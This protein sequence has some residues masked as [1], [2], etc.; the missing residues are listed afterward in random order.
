MHVAAAYTSAEQNSGRYVALAPGPRP[1]SASA[2]AGMVGLRLAL[3]LS[4]GLCAFAW[5]FF[6]GHAPLY[7]SAVSAGVPNA[8]A[9][10]LR[11]RSSRE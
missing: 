3:V 2:G 4:L 1:Q 11:D 5:R 10:A 9:G 8:T 7:R 6:R